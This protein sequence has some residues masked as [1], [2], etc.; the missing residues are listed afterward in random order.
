VGPDRVRGP[1]DATLGPV[2]FFDHGHGHGYGLDHHGDPEGQDSELLA[3]LGVG[4]RWSLPPRWRAE[5]HRG[6][7]PTDREGSTGDA[8]VDAGIASRAGAR[9]H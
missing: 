2:P 8:P 5:L 4:L 7:P 6:R 1:D 3:S 9:L